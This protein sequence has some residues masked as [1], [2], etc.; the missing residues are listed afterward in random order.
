MSVFPA[1]SRSRSRLAQVLIVEGLGV[2]MRAWRS[3]S[4]TL[5]LPLNSDGPESNMES[6]DVIYYAALQV[7]IVSSA[8]GVSYSLVK[9]LS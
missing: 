7:V 9:T 1:R 8:N 6:F 2:C 3:S 5:A 4:L